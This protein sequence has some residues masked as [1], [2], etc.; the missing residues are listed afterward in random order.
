M[1]GRL[2]RRGQH[3]CSLNELGPYRCVVSFSRF[4]G[5]LIIMIASNGHFCTAARVQCVKVLEAQLPSTGAARYKVHGMFER[6][7]GETARTLRHAS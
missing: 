2:P 5:R 4:F 3:L 6:H 7:F 1:A